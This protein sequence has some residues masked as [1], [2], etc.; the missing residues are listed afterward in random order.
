MLYHPQTGTCLG[1]V[2]PR[3]G[4]TARL[5]DP[6]RRC[7][8]VTWT[9]GVV[10]VPPQRQTSVPHG[11]EDHRQGSSRRDTGCSVRS[12]HPKNWPSSP[13]KDAATATELLNMLARSRYEKYT[14][15]CSSSSKKEITNITHS[16]RNTTA[17]K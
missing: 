3:W 9:I 12:S 13:W 17:Q 6:L 4:D 15:G 7:G 1:V 11:S 14:V 16:T 10:G 8:L 2:C 5:Q